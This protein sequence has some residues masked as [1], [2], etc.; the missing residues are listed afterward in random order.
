MRRLAMLLLLLSSF[1][2]IAQEYSCVE[3]AH[4]LSLKETGFEH[5]NHLLLL[6][7]KEPLWE[8]VESMWFIEQVACIPEGYELLVSHRQYGDSSTKLLILNIVNRV[9]YEIV[10]L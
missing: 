1:P 2:L 6:N 9:Q 10:G 3:H 5:V 4:T 8:L 7:G